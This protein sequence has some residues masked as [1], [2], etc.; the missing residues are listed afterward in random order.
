MP[1]DGRQSLVLF[2]RPTPQAERRVLGERPI[3]RGA[4]IDLVLHIRWSTG[5]DGFVEAWLDG[6][7]FTAGRVS[8]PTLYS[9]ISNYLRLGFYRAKGVP[10]AS[11]VYFDEV[12]LGGSY[13]AVAP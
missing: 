2:G 12:R 9:P 5:G 1:R 10:T 11:Q 6:R 8:G 4:W 13:Q 7:P 3:R